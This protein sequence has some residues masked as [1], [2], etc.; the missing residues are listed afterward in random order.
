MSSMGY[1]FNGSCLLCEWQSGGRLYVTY[2]CV[3][4]HVCTGHIYVCTYMCAQ[5]IFM[6][7]HIGCMWHIHVCT[8][9]LYAN[10]NHVGREW[11]C[12]WH[13]H[14][15]T[16]MCAQDIFMYA[17]T[18]V[19]MIY[20]CVHIQVVYDTLM[21]AHSTSLP[22]IHLTVFA[23]VYVCVEGTCVCVCVCSCAC[24]Y[25][26]RHKY[27]YACMYIM[28]TYATSRE[29]GWKPVGEKKR[30]RVNCAL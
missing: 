19:H 28:Y 6:C 21:Y 12:M 1:V 23:C 4:M 14:V 25:T 20:S 3:H 7:A 10:D 13:I 2:S 17:H 11:D 9:R 18:C 5:D 29:Q 30:V 27:T 22:I 16:Y 24:M 26:C 15:C 8:Y